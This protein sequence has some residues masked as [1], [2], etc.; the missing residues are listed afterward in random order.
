MNRLTIGVTSVLTVYV[1]IAEDVKLLLTEKPTDLV[2][3]I[4]GICCIAVF[5][6]EIVLSSI[7][8]T[9]Y[10]MGFFFIL[11]IIST[12]TLVLDLPWVSEWMF[13]D[14]AYDGGDGGTTNS[15]ATAKTQT[16]RLG[17]KAGRMVR[18]V[19][20]FRIVKLYKLVYECLLRNSA[21]SP[22]AP[23]L[24]AGDDLEGK[25]T[26]E[27]RVGKKLS[28][29]TTRRVIILVLLMLVVVPLLS[30][31]ESLK[32]A[33][34]AF[35][36]A[37]EVW[38][39]F[40]R[41]EQG[42][43]TRERYETALLRYVY[44]HNWFTGNNGE[45]GAGTFCPRSYYNTLF[46]V[47]MSSGDKQLL[48]QMTDLARIRPSTMEQWAGNV[49]RQNDMYNY[50]SMPPEAHD[51]L[52]SSWSADPPC[53][54][55]SDSSMYRFG[56][57]LLRREIGGQV[58][59][60]VGCYTDLRA[61]ER[62]TFYPRLM[63]SGEFN[64]IHFNFWFDQR[65]F[66]RV[67]AASS[68]G[69]TAFIC[70]VLCGTAMLFHN[71]VNQLVL[72]PVEAMIAKVDAIRINPL[73][74]AKMAEEKF[75]KEV[76]AARKSEIAEGVAPRGRFS[77]FEIDRAKRLSQ[78]KNFIACQGKESQEP[79]ETVVL[80]NTI[81]KLGSLLVL[82]FGEA[83]A[84][85]IR[86]NME[87]STA[88]VNV[89]LPGQRVEC[90]I[91][92][93]RIQNFSVAT[94]V[95]QSSVMTFVNQ[96]AEIIHGIADE[97]HGSA[98][99][100]NGDTF[101]LI[102][103]GREIA[104]PLAGAPD[105]E[106]ADGCRM[107]KLADI[108]IYAFG[109]IIAALNRSPTLAEYRGHPNLQQ[110]LGSHF[111]FHLSCGIHA[112]WAIEGAVG[113]E[114]KI[115]ASYLSPN[116]AVALN[117][118]GATHTYGVSLLVSQS[119]VELCC[120]EMASYCRLIDHVYIA[121]S[122]LPLKLYSVDLDWTVLEVDESAKPIKVWSR[123]RAMEARQFLEAEKAKKLNLHILRLFEGDPDICAMRGR[124][125]EEFFEIFKMGY[126]NYSEG[127][128]QVAV[129]FLSQTRT[130][131]GWND[132]PSDALIRFMSAPQQVVAPNR[133][134]THHTSQSDVP[135]QLQA[136]KGWRGIHDIRSSLS[137]AGAA[138][139]PKGGAATLV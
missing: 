129:R 70:V 133:N 138:A 88:G 85:I 76:K 119:V 57:S 124:F 136:P 39:S 41:M 58:D 109:K 60:A 7:G 24:G 65:R 77:F 33:E 94:E 128:W 95:L 82:G 25:A 122:I 56:F 126:H 17:A 15:A 134:Q 9:D 27:S 125:T 51:I 112:G 79:M 20:L 89:M 96:V 98:N 21:T 110:K 97:C 80:E 93:A 48:T 29:L 121:G 107:S 115:E 127:E 4:I 54:L 12:C 92:H 74:A 59:H 16:A 87:G 137:S 66:V 40:R 106:E 64:D 132:G 1:L 38:L 120:P 44:Y 14:N 84:E 139:G 37:D 5:S 13:D 111:R 8:I 75:A 103:R 135:R 34:A 63:T 50:G 105:P 102:W 18:I 130:M 72:Y 28:D 78:M 113:S 86:K 35:Y 22:L 2:F 90:V 32:F 108:S 118:E 49:S 71:D 52:T 99:R 81:I 62:T 26:N 30:P 67:E 47:D 10:F 46:Y 116:V 23:G 91:G 31:D 101:L 3:A 19:R 36:G 45:C 131:T 43:A 114:Y 42:L 83:G 123:R 53:G 117:V 104:D 69:I 73:K 68:L 100:N 6:V 55:E 11:D 61:Q